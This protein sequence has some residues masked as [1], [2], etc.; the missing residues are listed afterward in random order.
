MGS[1]PTEF[2]VCLGG[3]VKADQRSAS[4]NQLISW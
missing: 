3:G 2:G 1:Q 4:W